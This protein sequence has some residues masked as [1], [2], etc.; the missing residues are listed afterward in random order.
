MMEDWK[1][2]KL[3]RIKAELENNK[4]NEYTVSIKKKAL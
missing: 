2:D 3:Y 1:T 4:E